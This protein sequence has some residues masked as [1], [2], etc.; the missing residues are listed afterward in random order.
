MRPLLLLLGGILLAV[1]NPHQSH[2]VDYPW[3]AELSGDIGASN[4]GFVTR[5]QCMA[6]ISGIGGYCMPNPS[7][8]A[9][10]QQ[11]PRRRPAR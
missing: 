5:E 1:L 11:K 6:T 3:C 8:R 10:A 9:A 2:A 7:W 4:C